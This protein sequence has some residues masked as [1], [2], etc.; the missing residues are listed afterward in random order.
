MSIEITKDVGQ[1]LVWG[2]P[3]EYEK[4][5]SVI[6]GHSRWSIQYMLVFRRKGS[7]QLYGADFSVGATEYQDEEPFQYQD[8]IKCYEVAEE[9]RPTYVRKTDRSGK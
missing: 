5:A 9:A 7:Q 4:V 1:A 8:V 6:Q 3:C 2:E